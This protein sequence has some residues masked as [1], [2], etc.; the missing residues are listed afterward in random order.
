MDWIFNY[1][2]K[3]HKYEMKDS[4]QMFTFCFMNFLKKV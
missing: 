2:N 4:I 3:Q 1:K